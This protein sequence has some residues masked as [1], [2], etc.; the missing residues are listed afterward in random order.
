M[1]LAKRSGWGAVTEHDAAEAY[2]DTRLVYD[3]KRRVLWQTLADEVFSDY[4]GPDDAVLELGAG[5]CELVNALTARRRVAV[6]LWPGIKDYAAPGV[7]ALVTSATDLGDLLDA[8]FDVVFASNLVEHLTHEQFDSLL[9]ESNRVL[10]PGGRL[11]LIQPNFRL[12]PRTYFDDYTHV[13][14]WTDV[15]LTGF[16]ES[17]GWAI[18]QVQPRFLPLTVKSRLPVHSALIK[19]Y[20]RM[21]LKPLAGQ[22]LVVAQTPVS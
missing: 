5:W 4:V 17:R 13:S 20:L 16:L 7:E 21:P 18:E 15:G 19:T 8:D 11:I 22:M 14:I 3:E 2:F 12:C 6:D 1:A 9:A 10:K